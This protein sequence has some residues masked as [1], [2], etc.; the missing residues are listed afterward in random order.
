[1]A[2]RITARLHR[3]SR[4]IRGPE[5]PVPPRFRSGPNSNHAGFALVAVI[6]SL[7]LITLLGMAVI[8]GARYRTKVTSSVASVAA[9]AAAA[10][11]AI[12]LGITATLTTTPHQNVKFPLR[13]RMP[14][15]ERVLV[16]VE[17]E[18]GKVDL[19][20][21]TPAV[22]AR[23]FTALTRDQSTGAR[24]AERIME[25]RDPIRHQ[26]KDADVRSANDKPD[27]ARKT[28]FMTILQLDQIDGIPPDL[29]RTALRFVTVRSG[30]PE[31]D[32]D[33]ASPALREFLNL[34]QKPAGP[35]RGPPAIGS[36]TIR[37]DVRA[38][39]GARFIR[40]ALVSLGAE[41]GRPFVVREWRHGEIDST[42]LALTT[43]PRDDTQ[44]AERSC[45]R[46]GEA[47][48]S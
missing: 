31:P 34:D 33:V 10:E 12:N 41:N 15:G 19:N 20:T 11:S 29:F 28:R 1:V 14:G 46:V 3:S 17:E 23:L 42:P 30:R 2:N 9:A 7:G 40:E 6:W 26:A 13:C 21:A 25:F 4:S 43:Q 37:A 5:N 32:G 24:I 38:P 45:F 27:D 35:S 22:L 18:A 8:V 48:G 16:T 39:D 47:A 44:V 36:V